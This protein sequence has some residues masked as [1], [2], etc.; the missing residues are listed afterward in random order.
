MC[1]THGGTLSLCVLG[2]R[3]D[4]ASTRRAGGN[5]AG[6]REAGG[7]GIAGAAAGGIHGGGGGARDPPGA[8]A[9]LFHCGG[10]QGTTVPRQTWTATCALFESTWSERA[11]RQCERRLSSTFLTLNAWVD[12]GGRGASYDVRV[13]SMSS[14][15]GSCELLGVSRWTGRS[16]RRLGASGC[17]GYIVSARPRR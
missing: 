2:S 3:V 15:P 14:A 16:T 12:D 7:K 4:G 8:A 13:H 10:C 1:V 5:G 11:Q 17:V 9:R 6:A